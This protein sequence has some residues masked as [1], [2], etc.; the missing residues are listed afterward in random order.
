L[1]LEEVCIGI[2]NYEQCMPY[3]I[4]IWAIIFDIVFYIAM[5]MLSY[6]VINK[7]KLKWNARKSRKKNQKLSRIK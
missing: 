6:A 7:I 3:T 5:F 2:N 1:T 4:F